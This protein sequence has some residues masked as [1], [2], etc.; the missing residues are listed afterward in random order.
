MPECIGGLL[1]IT[2]QLIQ[3]SPPMHGRRVPTSMKC[4]GAAVSSL[5]R[6][7]TATPEKNIKEHTIGVA[8]RKNV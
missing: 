8:R 3:N 1:G 4:R 2:F 7:M 6:N 5:G